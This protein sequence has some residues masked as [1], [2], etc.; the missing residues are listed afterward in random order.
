[1]FQNDDRNGV[2][3]GQVDF[4]KW[5]ISA[6]ALLG[7]VKDRKRAPAFKVLRARVN[8]QLKEAALKLENPGVSDRLKAQF[9]FEYSQFVDTVK[10]WQQ[11]Q[12]ERM[13][14][15]KQKLAERLEAETATLTSRYRELERSLKLQHKRLALL[16]AAVT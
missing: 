4:N 16:T 14:E 11:L 13:Q 15:Q 1:M 8:M 7:L 10:E 2:R 6:C 3:W 9:D 5:F 12:V